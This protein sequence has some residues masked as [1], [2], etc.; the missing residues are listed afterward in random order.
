MSSK[1]PA[2]VT[3]LIEGMIA[4]RDN[5]RELLE[6]AEILA[7]EDRHSRSFALMYTACEELGKFA[8]LEIGAKRLING[9]PP[10]WKR[11]WKRFRSHESKSAQLE[12]Q[13]QLLTLSSPDGDDFSGFAKMLF[14]NGLVTRNAA[15]YVDEG[16][17]GVFRRPSDMNFDVPL[18]GMRALAVHALEA[19]DQPG[20]THSD[21]ETH[22]RIKPGDQARHALAKLQINLIERSREAGLGRE[23]ILALI[24]KHWK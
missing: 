20:A 5:A 21:I 24:K 3:A 16:D 18:P 13:I 1:E 10:D 7:R 9:N 8:I 11:F 14:A 23:E 12:V 22:L 19:T 6:E 4:C 2:T 15:L 17:L